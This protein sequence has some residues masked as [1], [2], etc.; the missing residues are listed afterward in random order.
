M[1]TPPK[2]V[3]TPEERAELEARDALS[4]SKLLEAAKLA[5]KRDA[6]T[7][8]FRRAWNKA[9]KALQVP[10]EPGPLTA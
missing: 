4:Q 7:G 9:T 5:S 3:L 6:K 1:T 8:T 10:E 2:P